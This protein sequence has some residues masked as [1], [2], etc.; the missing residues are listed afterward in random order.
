MTCG[1]CLR[2]IENDSA[3]CRHCGARA[4]AASAASPRRRLYRSETDRKVGGV[5]GGIAEYFS[6]DPTLVRLIAVVLAIYPGVVVFGMIAYLVAWLV[7]PP[8][9]VVPMQS[10]TASA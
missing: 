10:A 1:R 5:C 2:D 3:Y 7:I 9:P 4:V 6:V 8:A